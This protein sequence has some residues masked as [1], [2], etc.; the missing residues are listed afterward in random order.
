[1]PA[2]E[3]ASTASLSEAER[4]PAI[5]MVTT[6]EA[7]LLRALWSLTLQS[8]SKRRACVAS[9]LVLTAA[10]LLPVKRAVLCCKRLQ[11]APTSQHQCVLQMIMLML[12]SLLRTERC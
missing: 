10:L 6:A 11:H 5:D 1:M 7:M 4:G 12:F 2:L 3:A 9:N 8:N